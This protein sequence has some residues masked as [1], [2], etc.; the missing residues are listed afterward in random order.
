MTLTLTPTN[1]PKVNDKS[2]KTFESLTEAP[3]LWGFKC[4]LDLL[5]QCGGCLCLLVDL[6]QGDCTTLNALS[7]WGSEQMCQVISKSSQWVNRYRADKKYIPCDFCRAK[8]RV[9]VALTL[10]WV[11]LPYTEHCLSIMIICGTFLKN[12]FTSSSYM[13][14]PVLLTDRQMNKC[15]QNNVCLRHNEFP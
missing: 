1:V 2:D 14:Q 5:S 12:P 7:Q 9:C 8:W 11:S 3:E 13:E 15:R 4:D 10:N 6:E